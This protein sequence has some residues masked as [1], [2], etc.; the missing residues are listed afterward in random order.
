MVGGGAYLE[1]QKG[2]KEAPS[3][4]KSVAEVLEGVR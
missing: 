1:T 4:E 3:C 2:C